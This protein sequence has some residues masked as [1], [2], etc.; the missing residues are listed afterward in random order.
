[1]F[2]VGCRSDSECTP[3]E[4]CVNRE[5]VDP[6]K[7]TWCGRGAQ[8]IAEGSR[9]RC[10]CPPG[11]QGDPHSLCARPECTSNH[12]C[13]DRLACVA[14]KCVDPCT[15]APGALCL[16]RDHTPS[17]RCPPGYIGNPHVSCSPGTNRNNL[18]CYISFRFFFFKL[19]KN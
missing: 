15:C 13:P 8:C 10:V 4:A 12:E 2:A 9:A 16:V 19:F 14:N 7:Y 3:R 6:C 18:F 17:C 1:M 5:C 11:T